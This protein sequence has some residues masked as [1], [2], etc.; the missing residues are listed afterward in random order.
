HDGGLCIAVSADGLHFVPLVN[1]PVLKHNHDITNVT[2]DDL[3]NHF[4]ATFSTMQK[5]PKFMQKNFTQERRTTAQ[6]FSKDL[7]NWDEPRIVLCADDSKEDGLV[8][9][10]AMN[11]FVNRGPLR[12]GMVKLLRDDLFCDEKELLDKRNGG[13]GTGYTAL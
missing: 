13:Y 7:V 12:I 5:L 4:V 2:W 10:Y 9:F 1:H 8:Q 6:S 11:G 3:R